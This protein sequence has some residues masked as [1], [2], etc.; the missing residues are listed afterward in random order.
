ML[1]HY[2]VCLKNGADC[3]CDEWQSVFRDPDPAAIQHMMSLLA[4]KDYGSDN[5]SLLISPKN[6]NCADEQSS[7]PWDQR[8]R[9]RFN[10]EPVNEKSVRW[11]S[12]SNLRALFFIHRDKLDKGKTE[13]AE[14]P[15][16]SSSNW[17]MAI[18]RAVVA[19]LQ[20]WSLHTRGLDAAAILWWENY[21]GSVSW[22]DVIYALFTPLFLCMHQPLHPI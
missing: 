16:S 19:D 3:D 8:Q 14:T 4:S 22:R 12:C 2:V 6:L 1:H 15:T 17:T 18:P 5:V 10:E 20:L 21:I 7:Q 13:K 9:W 11:P